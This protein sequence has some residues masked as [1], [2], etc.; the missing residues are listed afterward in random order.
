M[1]RY[2][3]SLGEWRCIIQTDH[4]F[5]EH[6]KPTSQRSAMDA[7]RWRQIEQILQSA[8]ELEPVRREAY[9]EKACAGDKSLRNEVDS[10]LAQEGHSQ[11]LFDSPALD[12]AARA[13]A[14]E[15][16]Q[17]PPQPN[18]TGRA[19]S[20]YRILEKLGE[21]G[22]GVVY[23]ARD[24][25][26]DRFVA[27]KVLP[28]EKVADPQ[29]Q[30]RFVRE[31]KAA[32]ALNH[33]N[34]VT[35]H[36][37]ESADGVYFI[38]ME[39]VEGKTLAHLVARKKLPLRELLGIAVQIADALAAAHAH[40]IVHRDLKP[41]NVMLTGAGRVKLLD[42]GLAKL[43]E[44]VNEDGSA[45]SEAQ[46]PKTATGIV[47]GTAAY[48]SPEQA[49]GKPV[50]ARTDVFSFGGLLYEM[51]TGKRAFAGHS[52]GS[53]LSMLLNH[54]PPSVR[55][56]D[57][58]VPRDLERIVE[59]CLKKDPNRRL[60]SMADVKLQL[61][62]LKEE[63]DSGALTAPAAVRPK[64]SRLWIWVAPA[65]LF[66]AAAAVW[67]SWPSQPVPAEPE[68][69]LTRLTYHGGFTTD[70]ALSPD[71]RLLAY[72]SDRAG[73][74]GMDIW[75]QQI[76]GG[77]ALRLT[78]D[79]AENREPSFSPDGTKIVFRSTRDGGGI[80]TIPAL[81]GVSRRIASGGNNPV[82]APGGD[83]VAYYKGNTGGAV[84]ANGKTELLV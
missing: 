7:E 52:T 70:P 14:Q 25:H 16:T 82:F 26:L 29:R 35:V 68:A 15:Q 64:P 79:G 20:H 77:E 65:V 28:P 43:V 84:L 72:A 2:A 39:W 59:L 42:F 40:G 34:I 69:M 67:L 45:V 18:L 54:E 30:W 3:V 50:D 27:L 17:S 11:G 36:D 9:L 55:S 6:L 51:A 22:M 75:V 66:L 21:G 19:L 12:V 10:L 47:V 1:P 53:T 32:S 74:G 23:K 31:A 13:L 57:P 5:S 73:A 41:G 44:V 49:E 83:S 38:A 8:L 33:P 4:G 62:S 58:D 71:G 60:Q 81:G 24:T 48:M 56:L 76:G 80:Y 37:I 63:L 78:R 46:P 61:E